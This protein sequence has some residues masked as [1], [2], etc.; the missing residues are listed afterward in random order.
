MVPTISMKVV[1]MVRPMV[2]SG[3]TREIIFQLNTGLEINSRTVQFVRWSWCLKKGLIW[4]WQSFRMSWGT[5]ESSRKEHDR[6][7]GGRIWVVESTKKEIMDKWIN[8]RKDRKE[9]GTQVWHI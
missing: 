5:V 4:P 7:S 6:V 9:E 1:Y 2:T 8:N 3:D